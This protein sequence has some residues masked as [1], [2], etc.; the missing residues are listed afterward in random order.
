LIKEDMKKI[1]GLNNQSKLNEIPKTEEIFRV[2]QT[3]F[4]IPEMKNL[5][6]NNNNINKSPDEN[7]INSNSN[8]TNNAR[9]KTPF[10]IKK[11]ENKNDNS[12]SKEII[13]NLNRV[14]LN[15]NKIKL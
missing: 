12:I 15:V 9:P 7:L 14:D 6:N 11:F 8:T 1:K 3:K 5:N 2:S 10:S 4:K 13:D